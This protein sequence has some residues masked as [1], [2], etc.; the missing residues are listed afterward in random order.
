MEDKANTNSG[1]GGGSAGPVIGAVILLAVIVVGGLYFWSQRG[2]SEA[3]I[4]TSELIEDINT[5]SQSDDTASIET[6]LEAT[7]LEVIDVEFNAS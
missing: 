1:Q 6:D 5:Q 3:D 2:P 4:E 7:D